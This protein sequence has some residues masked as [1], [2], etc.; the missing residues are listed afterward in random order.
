MTDDAIDFSAAFKE[1]KRWLR[2]QGKKVVTQ[3][4]N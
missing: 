3:G 1:Q 2:V 4:K